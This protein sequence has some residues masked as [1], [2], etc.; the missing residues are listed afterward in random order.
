MSNPILKGRP[1]KK[2]TLPIEEIHH[3]ASQKLYDIKSLFPEQYKLTLVARNTSMSHADI[4]LTED[5]DM[6]AV[7]IAIDNSKIRKEDIYG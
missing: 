5:T 4:V 7:K 3:T 1:E 2:T 6:E